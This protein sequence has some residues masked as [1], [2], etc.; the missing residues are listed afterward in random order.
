MLHVWSPKHVKSCF[1]LVDGNFSTW[2]SWGNCSKS[3]G[4]GVQVRT[5]SCTDPA[6]RGGGRPCQGNAFEIIECHVLKCPGKCRTIHHSN[7]S[8]HILLFKDYENSWIIMESGPY[9]S[10]IDYVI[11]G[12]VCKKPVTPDCKR[13]SL[14]YFHIVFLC[15]LVILKSACPFVVLSEDMFGYRRYSPL[16]A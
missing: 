9:D 2:S 4:D 5:R 13:L 10:S 11:C 1:V 8:W 6:P 16:V 15:S 12:V 3:C 14:L 7:E